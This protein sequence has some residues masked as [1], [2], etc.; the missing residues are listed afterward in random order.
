MTRREPAVDAAAPAP[1]R[2][3]AGVTNKRPNPR[4]FDDSTDSS[5]GDAGQHQTPDVAVADGA[6]SPGRFRFDPARPPIAGR[7]LAATASIPGRAVRGTTPAVATH[8]PSTATTG[9]VSNAAVTDAARVGRLKILRRLGAGGM[10]VVYA[11]YDPELEREVAVKLIHGDSDTAS[12][13]LF[14]E[15]QALAK[16]THPNIVAVYDVGRHEGQVWVSMEFVV[17]RTLGVWLEQERPRWRPI[18][19]VIL[20]AARGIAAAHAEGLLH[21]DIKPENIMVGDDGRTRVMDFGLTR[22]A[23]S[24]E[25]G[26][27]H[28]A[29][30]SPLSVEL[31]AAGAIMGTPAYMAPEQF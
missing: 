7:E 18:L 25:Q 1:A 17:G 22:V 8:N 12:A 30:A 19:A 26:S 16:L 14:R 29:S 9:P 3:D 23:S 28:D 2:P 21:R 13:R 4:V 24:R 20:Q 31:T 10:G 27:D 5:P 15:A 11:A 6:S